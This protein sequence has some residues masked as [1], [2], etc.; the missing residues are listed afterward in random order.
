MAQALSERLVDEVIAV[1]PTIEFPHA[2]IREALTR[3]CG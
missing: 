3:E 2:L 1:R